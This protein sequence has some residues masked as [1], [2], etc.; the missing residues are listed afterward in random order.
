[1]VH[2]RIVEINKEIARLQAKLHQLELDLAAVT[3]DLKANSKNKLRLYNQAKALDG[4]IHLLKEKEQI[5]ENEV[6]SL[7]YSYHGQSV[8]AY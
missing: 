8:K 1:M 3:T 2:G 6:A 5:L 4:K 7:R